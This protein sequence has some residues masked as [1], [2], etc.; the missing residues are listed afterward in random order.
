MFLEDIY[1]SFVS[2]L[3]GNYF[4]IYSLLVVS[5][6]VQLIVW[7]DSFLKGLCMCLVVRK[8][9]FVSCRRSEEATTKG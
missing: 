4:V 9:Y 3:A 2:V 7:K 6:A 5:L 1:L 8:P